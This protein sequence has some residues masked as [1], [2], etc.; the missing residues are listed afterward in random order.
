MNKIY[1]L[2]LLMTLISSSTLFAQKINQPVST[3]AKNLYPTETNSAYTSSQPEET[4]KPGE[5]IKDRCGFVTQMSKA[6]AAG[7]D[8]AAFENMISQKMASIKASRGTTIINYVIPVIFHVIHDWHCRRNG[9]EYNR[10]AGI[11][12][13]RSV[14]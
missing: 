8:R 4:L 13:N 12:A 6:V 9:C 14:E 1:S 2:L 7:Y 10:I 5:F 3:N 11:S